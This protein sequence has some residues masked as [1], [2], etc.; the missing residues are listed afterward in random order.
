MAEAQNSR[1]PSVETKASSA[2]SKSEDKYAAPPPNTITDPLGRSYAVGERLGKGGF[3]ICYEATTEA[4]Q[5]RPS[6]VA[7]KIVKTRMPSKVEEKVSDQRKRPG[8]AC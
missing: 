1:K 8:K 2:S 5:K 7:L 6:K 3:A 4:Q